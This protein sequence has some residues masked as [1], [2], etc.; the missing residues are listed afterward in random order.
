MIVAATGSSAQGQGRETAY[1]Q[2]VCDTL[3]IAFARVRIANGDTQSTP[4]GI[5]ALASR[6][7]AIGGSALLLA[8]RAF[9]A[10]RLGLG[11]RDARLPASRS[12]RCAH[13]HRARR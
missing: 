8:A 4:A 1:A 6:G 7:T 2:I 3:G 12:R 13:G 11:R 5:G 10:G 9:R